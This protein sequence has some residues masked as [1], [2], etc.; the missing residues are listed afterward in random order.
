M[1][2]KFAKEGEFDVEGEID[3]VTNTNHRR[4][5]KMKNQKVFKYLIKKLK[6]YFKW[7]TQKNSTM[8]RS[9]IKNQI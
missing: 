4:K 8:K 2:H 7:L 3:Q 1:P 5:K 9:S 6:Y